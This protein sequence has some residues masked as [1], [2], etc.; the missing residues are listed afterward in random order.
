MVQPWLSPNPAA[1]RSATVLRNMDVASDDGR[2]RFVVSPDGSG[3]NA[4]ARPFRIGRAAQAFDSTGASGSAP[5][6]RALVRAII[7]D[8]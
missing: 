7:G 8:Q 4:S 2:S 5:T 3:P 6:T 1:Y